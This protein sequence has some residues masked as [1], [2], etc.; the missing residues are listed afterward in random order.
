M[1]RL[2]S[3]QVL[4]KP[5]GRWSG[6]GFE[7]LHVGVKMATKPFNPDRGTTEAFNSLRTVTAVADPIPAR[8]LGRPSRR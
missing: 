5:F 3:K 7:I 1:G 8:C 4:C 6:R 2:L